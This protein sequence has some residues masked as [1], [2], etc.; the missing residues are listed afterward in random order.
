[1]NTIDVSHESDIMADKAPVEHV[2][3]VL[4]RILAEIGKDGCELSCSFVSDGTMRDLNHAY[5]GKDENTDIL[6]FVQ[7][8]EGEFPFFPEDGEPQILG[9]LVISLD[10]MDRNCEVF[11]VSAEEELKRLLIHGVLHVTGWDHQ[12]N[13][14]QEP[15]LVRQEEL[16][17]ILEKESGA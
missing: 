14:E 17:R 7:D 6:S 12:T 10:A 4:A 16:L 11:S 9:D 5:R 3:Q 2:R 13:G 1:M 15:M 8:D